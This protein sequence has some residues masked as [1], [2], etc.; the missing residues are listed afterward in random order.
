M[1]LYIYL[2]LFKENRKLKDIHEK[3]VTSDYHQTTIFF[4]S[5]SL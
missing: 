5:S 3:E 4:L 2:V 1:A